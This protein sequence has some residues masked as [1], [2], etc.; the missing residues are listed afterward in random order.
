ME[1][2]ETKETRGGVYEMRSWHDLKF[3][4]KAE[5]RFDSTPKV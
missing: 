3:Q 1:E 2:W 4:K 5:K